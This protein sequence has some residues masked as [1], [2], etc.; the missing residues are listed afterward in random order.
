[1]KLPFTPE[2]MMSRPDRPT[3]ETFRVARSSASFWVTILAIAAP[4]FF[5]RWATTP[6]L[7]LLPWWLDLFNIPVVLVG[8]LFL[9]ILLHELGHL[10]FA[11]L[12][13]FK[14][15][16]L[17]L[18]PLKLA[19]TV[20]G[21]RLLSSG[22]TGFVLQGRVLAVPPPALWHEP[23]KLRRRLV[24]F[25]AGGPA[26]TLLQAVVLGGMLF[27]TPDRTFNQ[28]GRSSLIALFLLT[29][30]IL[31]W[32][33][34]PMKVNGI[35]NDATQILQLWRGGPATRRLI[36]LLVLQGQLVAGV[37]PR[38]LDDAA[39]AQALMLSDGSADEVAARLLAV[40]RAEDEG[41]SDEMGELLGELLKK[42]HQLPP[43]Q[44]SASIMWQA[45]F[46]EA[47]HGQDADTAQ[48]WLSL[49]SKAAHSPVVEAWL[50]RTLAELGIA[51][52]T[53]R[54]QE[55]A[56]LSA[57]ADLLLNFTHSAGAIAPVREWLAGLNLPGAAVSPR[58]P[59]QLFWKPVLMSLGMTL[60]VIIALTFML[61]ILLIN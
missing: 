4:G 5:L 18:G 24:W 14:I 21:W 55:A 34:Y 39:L 50:L 36:A 2:Q 19:R 12:A 49:A 28:V 46:F 57:Q 37:R 27:L 60:L 26:V 59:W 10:G 32:I 6:R 1:M 31:A 7:A 17:I 44:R 13:G 15:V 54:S 61:L 3:R 40:A 8:G 33:F 58:Q 16:Y 43:P 9:T 35:P 29:T 30:M 25:F 52:Q 48:Q 56:D 41:R 20:Q 47:I 22:L 53:E 45:A 11:R 51:L 23:E 42:M 38:D